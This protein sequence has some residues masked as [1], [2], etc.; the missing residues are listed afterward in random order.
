MAPLCGTHNIYLVSIFIEKNPG[1]L[2]A[3]IFY[4]NREKYEQ[5]RIELMDAADFMCCSMVVLTAWAFPLGFY[6]LYG[7]NMNEEGWVEGDSLHPG[8]DW[9][10][11]KFLPFVTL[12]PSIY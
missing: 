9:N 2:S 11:W 5:C 10:C 7:N 12:V 4:L 1:Y 3:F 8:N 6:H